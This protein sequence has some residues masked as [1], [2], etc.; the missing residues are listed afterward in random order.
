[1]STTEPITSG[2]PLVCGM[3]V[4]LA[5]LEEDHIRRVLAGSPSITDAAITLGIDQ[6]T[7]YRKRKRLGLPPAKVGRKY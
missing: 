1:M 4:S 5:A 6:A 2:L 7:L 3:P